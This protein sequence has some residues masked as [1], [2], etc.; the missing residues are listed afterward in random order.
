MLCVRY[1]PDEFKLGVNNDRT[2]CETS[3]PP[4]SSIPLDAECAG[5][6]AAHLLDE[7]MHGR[8]VPPLTLYNPLEIASRDSSLPHQ[9][10]DA[11]VTDLPFSEIAAQ[12]GQRSA[13][14]LADTFHRRFGRTMT[15][16]R[17]SARG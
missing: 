10:D 7:Q 16:M 4:L 17:L 1:S 15:E 2:L 5:Y 3:L 9:T 8:K 12:C 11:L 13:A 6:T 14:H